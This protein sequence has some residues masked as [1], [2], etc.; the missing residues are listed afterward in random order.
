MPNSHPGKYN[1]LRKTFA[2]LVI[3]CMSLFNLTTVINFLITLQNKGSINILAENIGTFG[4]LSISLFRF[5][6]VLSKDGDRIREII[7]K[8]EKFYQ[9][10]VQDQLT[11]EVA[12]YL[13]VQK[14]LRRIVGFVYALMLFQLYMM[15]I[16]VSIYNYFTNS[17]VEIEPVLYIFSP[18]DESSRSGYLTEYF[19]IVLTGA[20]N[21]TFVI[22]SEHLFMNLM[23]VLCME[24][25]IVALNL[26]EIDPLKDGNEG[27]LNKMKEQI[28]IHQKLIEIAQQME[29]IYSL[30][31]LMDIFMVIA[32]ACV[33]AILAV[34]RKNL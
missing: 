3:I 11:F 16:Y 26:N 7:V 18:F 1:F 8:M 22:I 30:F 28:R 25:D 12:E 9:K 33:A 19:F 32:V 6:T 29:K 5:Y 21:M 10:S 13:K 20:P 23:S 14:L 2:W 24:F 27:A 31:F 4:V 34:V 17:D 15:P